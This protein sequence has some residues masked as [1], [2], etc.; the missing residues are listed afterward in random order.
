MGERRAARTRR[1][2]LIS[3]DATGAQGVYA[4]DAESEVP[5]GWI[6][7][8]VAPP[9][10]NGCEPASGPPVATARAWPSRGCVENLIRDLKLVALD[11]NLFP[12]QVTTIHQAQ[13]M[14]SLVLEAGAEGMDRGVHE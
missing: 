8:Q 5:E 13:R 11:G 4:I 6:D 1:I 10:I 9:R 2:R 12:G 3:P 14:L 7:L